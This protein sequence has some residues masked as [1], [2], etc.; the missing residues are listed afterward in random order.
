MSFGLL[1][2]GVMSFG[3]MLFGVMSFGVMSF[4]V[5]SFGV[6]S[7]GI[8]SVYHKIPRREGAK[9]IY[10]IQNGQQP[11]SSFIKFLFSTESRKL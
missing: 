7:F 8:L 5:M 2:F 1:S 10:P 11:P 9:N 3:V 4:G 6:M